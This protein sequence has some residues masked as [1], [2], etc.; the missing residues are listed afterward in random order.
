MGQENGPLNFVFCKMNGLNR[1]D[2]DVGT[3][4]DRFLQ[5]CD[6][7]SMRSLVTTVLHNYDARICNEFLDTGSKG[8]YFDCKST[9][10]PQTNFSILKGEGR[11]L[12]RSYSADAA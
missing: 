9:K 4:F 11:V 12:V 1:Q 2:E 5:N 8:F 6:S 10:N 3:S 7:I